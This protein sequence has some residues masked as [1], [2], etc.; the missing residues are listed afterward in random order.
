MEFHIINTLINELVDYAKMLS[1]SYDNFNSLWDIVYPS[2]DI[3]DI[4]VED[5]ITNSGND[6]NFEQHMIL[7]TK[8]TLPDFKKTVSDYLSWEISSLL[9]ND[10]HTD[11]SLGK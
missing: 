6:W 8:P 11:S 5:F 2:W 1:L 9:K 3:K 4:Y 7:D 10:N